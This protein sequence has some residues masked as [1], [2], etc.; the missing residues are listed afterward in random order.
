MRGANL[1]Y[2]GQANAHGSK[3]GRKSH[4]SG[5]QGRCYRATVHSIR[6][7]ITSISIPQLAES[8]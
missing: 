4:V 6:H 2:L 8:V 5:L 7:R 1:S 3:M